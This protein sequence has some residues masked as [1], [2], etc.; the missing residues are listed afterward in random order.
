[1]DQKSMK[2]NQKSIKNHPKIVKNRPLG[3]LGGVLGTSWPQ[4]GTKSETSGEQLVR[5]TP[6]APPV[7]AQNPPKIGPKSDHKCDH[8]W[9]RI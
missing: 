9:D 8:F 1:M 5:W 7:G 2:I 4:E 6:L 3:A